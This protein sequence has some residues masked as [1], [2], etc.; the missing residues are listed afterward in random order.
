MMV[1]KMIS[2]FKQVIF[3]LQPFVFL[4]RAYA[5]KRIFKENPKGK[6]VGRRRPAYRNEGIKRK[7]IIQNGPR[8]V[9]N[10]AI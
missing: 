8:P 5:S 1:W 9:Q 4:G 7:N 3:R 6:V 2:L 10:R